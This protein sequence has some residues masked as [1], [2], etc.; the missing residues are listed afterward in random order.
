MRMTRRDWLGTWSVALAAGVPAFDVLAQAGR[1]MPKLI[2]GDSPIEAKLAWPRDHA[3]HMDSRVEWW[4]FKGELHPSAGKTLG[5]HVAI[6]RSQVES[7]QESKSR[8]APKHVLAARASLTDLDAREQWFDQRVARLGFG[9]ADVAEK[10]L[11]IRLH[12]WSLSRTAAGDASVFQGRILGKDFQLDLKGTQ[13]QPPLLHGEGGVLHRDPLLSYPTRYYSM[14]QLKVE[15]QVT[16]RRSRQN[17]SGSA[18]LD[19]GWGRRM[20]SPDAVGSDWVCM[21]L[22]DGGALVVFQMRRSDGTPSF[23]GAAWRRPGKPDQVFHS[24]EVKMKAGELWRSPAS[25]GQYPVAWTLELAG[26]RYTVKARMREQEVDGGNEIGD[27]F[28]EGLSDLTD[29]Q[30]RLIGSGF[31]EMTGY[32]A[33]LAW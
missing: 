20:M 17:V 7:A 29:A 26:T 12:D 18:W 11:D 4:S 28:W 5:F 10:E 30:G 9:L 22:Q 23:A 3:A 33:E 15:G 32:S 2:S 24:E 27:F 6:I 14:P 25:G 8:F 13:A 31:L 21:N 19:H 16:L 1:P